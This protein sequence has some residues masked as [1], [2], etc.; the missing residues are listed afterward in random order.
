MKNENKQSIE[1]IIKKDGEVVV[2]EQTNC[3]F[4]ALQVG[5]G[6]RSL[7]L[8]D[9]ATIETIAAVIAGLK[10]Q[11]NTLYN[12]N[13]EIKVVEYIKETESKF[14]KRLGLGGEE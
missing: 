4:V 14:L 2:N 3:I 7:S 1:I 6:V 5:Q 8:A 10:K 12:E 11:I 9:N 13:P